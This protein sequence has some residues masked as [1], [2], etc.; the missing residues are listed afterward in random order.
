MK[1]L[2]P[3]RFITATSIYDGHDS[4]I[5]IVRRILQDQGAE[6]VHLGHN[7]GVDEIVRAALQ[8]SVDGI[9]ISSY[10]GGHVEFFQYLIDSLKNAGA[11][12]I[13][14]FGG[15][16]GTI[17]RDEIEQ[18]EGYGVER[19]Y[20]PEDGRRMGL[21]GMARDVLQRTYDARIQC[22]F[23]KKASFNDHYSIGQGLTCIEQ[24]VNCSFNDQEEDNRDNYVPVV[25]FTGTGGAGKSSVMDELLSR[26]LR[27]FPAL[28]IAV[29]ALDPTRYKSGGALLGDRIRLNSLN[30]GRIY[31]RSM[32]TRRKDWATSA[33]MADAVSFLKSVGFGLVLVETA[34]TG[35]ADVGIVD[36]VD[37]SLY[38]MT[39]EY[40]APSQLEKVQML[41]FA[42][43]VVLNK[44]DKRGAQD[45]L[46]DIRRQWRRDHKAFDMPDDD[47]PVIATI[48]NHWHDE[49]V[50]RLLSVLCEKLGALPGQHKCWQ[51]TLDERQRDALQDSVIV[52]THRTHYLTLIS[53]NG[54]AARD[55]HK[56][57]VSAASLVHGIY[58]SL[59]ALGDDALPA[60]LSLY[61]NDVLEQSDN[62]GLTQLRKKYNQALS[63][64]SDESLSLLRNWPDNQKRLKE[65]NYCYDVRGQAFEGTN[66]VQSLSQLDI[67]KVAL[68]PYEN[69]GEQ[70][71]FL[72]KENL[73][74]SYP[75]TAGVFPYR[76]DQEDPTRMF[77]GEGTPERTNRRFHYLAKGQKSIRLSTAFDPI[78]LYGEDADA[79]PDIYGRIGMS[80]VS[81]TNLDDMKKLYS[82][83]DLCLPSTSVSMTINGPAPVILAWFLNAA[84]DQQV[85]KH[86]KK[87]G[88][89]L[90]AEKKILALY[91]DKSRPHYQG[92][93]P[94]GNDGLG[95]ALLGVTG[96]ELVDDDTYQHIRSETLKV[97]R[98]T[99]QADILK[100][101]QAQ[102]ECIFPLELGLRMM[103]D[104][105]QYFINNDVR[106]YYSV[107]VSGYHIAEAGANPITQLAF[108]LANGFTLVEYYLSRGMGVDEFAAQMSFFFSN[109]MDPEYAVIGRVAR[110]IWA[111]AMRDV[112][113]ANARSQKLKYHIQTSG[114][115]LHAQT[116][117]FNDIRTTLQALYAIYDNC[118]SLH[119]NA[120]DEALTTPTEESVRRALAIQLII[121]RELGLNFNQNPLQ[122]SFIIDEL[123]DLA[124][125]AV[126]EEFNRLS[127]RGGVLGAMETLYQR[128]KIQDEALYYEQRK[129]NGTLPIVGVNT[130]MHE[131]SQL[132]AGNASLIRSEEQ[133]KQNQI[134]SVSCFQENHNSEAGSA[135][136]SL[137]KVVLQE[138]NTFDVLMEVTKKC[139]LG[140]LTKAL[141]DVVGRY[142]RSV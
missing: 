88:L 112:Y 92:E 30:S 55:G 56:K 12:H 119:T 140:Q 116:L 125:E 7:R 6:V 87:N 109:G 24:G 95:L 40:G 105:Q 110:R 126:Y 34:G 137:Q 100:E 104:I 114:R 98:G 50:Q 117:G 46:R 52:P 26:L 65:P 66:Y 57:Q 68:P 83:F 3:L 82:G 80:G 48:A 130:F 139:T 102:N 108:T 121:N 62:S 132:A 28:N 115:T 97:I 16:G 2:I 42:D 11:G 49:G 94:D 120:Y 22:S 59:Q 63:R 74:G 13:R 86:L 136:A 10:Q 128:G 73:P 37:L 138:G 133:E 91:K 33:A 81:V 27:Y 134:D 90:A 85:E 67:P 127:E 23:P 111:R 53:D 21:D 84:I 106:N 70:L 32:A 113:N 122:G 129:H 72:L 69:W 41:D 124:E 54:L 5:N 76:R 9:A 18:L 107:S 45:A 61:G 89:W 79:R 36:H 135:L 8:E 1:A 141:Y 99:L 43:I 19:L 64:L 58:L 20:T 35:Q 14:V 17:T 142:R 96:D 31:M 38:V 39:N 15:G 51:F 29:L 44:A 131:D 4:A 123:T 118:N 71:R 78:T 77:A 25:G 103:G 93:L 60:P 101:D 75:Y 47:V